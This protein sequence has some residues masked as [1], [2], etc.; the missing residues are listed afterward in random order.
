MRDGNVREDG[1]AKRRER[2]LHVWAIVEGVVGVYFERVVVA[3]G[4]GDADH[5]EDGGESL[6]NE[7]VS[8][9]AA[10]VWTHVLVVAEGVDLVVGGRPM[11]VGVGARLG[12]AVC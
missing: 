11:P 10:G 3:L 1:A 5:G 7:V 4:V 8:P 2:E 6:L 9:R 12:V